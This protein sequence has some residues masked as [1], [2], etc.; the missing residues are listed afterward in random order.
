MIPGIRPRISVHRN[1]N[2]NMAVGYAFTQGFRG[3]EPVCQTGATGPETPGPKHRYCAAHCSLPLPLT[4][5]RTHH[6]NPPTHPPP[7]QYWLQE[8]DSKDPNLH[9][10][11]RSK[12]L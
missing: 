3:E 10:K 11:K 12:E 6:V 4:H 2:M 7:T 5:A 1:V 9:Q 8:A